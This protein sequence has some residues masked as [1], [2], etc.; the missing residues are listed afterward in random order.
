MAA[1]SDS[2]QSRPRVQ[3]RRARKT[4]ALLRGALGAL[5]HEKPYDDIVVKEILSRANVGRSTFY[6]HFRD[7]DELLLECMLELLRSEPAAGAARPHEAIVRFSRP[8]LEH[9]ERHRE[10]EALHLEPKGRRAIHE[11]LL[12][13]IGLLIE[14]EVERALRR[15]AGTV[16][17]FS[18]ELL[19]RWIAS[20]FVLTLHWWVESDTRLSA[21]EVD[22]LFRALVEP[23]L[24]EVLGT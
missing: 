20:T 5:I 9:I 11:H 4:R 10:T 16:R 15:K 2:G 17:Q 12:D 7:K 24:A 1:R 19:A 22:G 13:A 18:P 8:V 3:D 6:T 23:S 14:G 21:Q